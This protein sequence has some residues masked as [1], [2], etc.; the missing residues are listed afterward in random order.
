MCEHRGNRP[1]P[2]QGQPG[3]QPGPYGSNNPYSSNSSNGP[4]GP[5]Q[6]THQPSHPYAAHPSSPYSPFAPPEPHRS[7]WQRLR[8]DDWPPLRQV[9]RVGRQRIPVRIWALVLLPCTSWGVL[10]PMMCYAL[11]RTARRRA[12]QVFPPWR[13]RRVQD[14]DVLRVQRVRAWT[15][16]VISL[17]ILVVYGEPGDFQEARDQYWQRLLITPWL[18]LLSAPVAIAVLFR[19][20][21]PA[22]R[23][24]MR[25]RLRAAGK[26]AL[27]Y[28]G[29]LMAVPLLGVAVVWAL[30]WTGGFVTNPFLLLP[31]YMALWAP[32]L[33]VFFFVAFASAPAVRG[34]FNT[35][36]AH[37]ALPALLTAVLVWELTLVGLLTAGLPPGPPLL[38]AAVLAGGPL[39]VTAVAWWEIHRLRTRHG[40][41]LRA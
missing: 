31:T 30:E 9:L 13:E 41:E 8:E 37:A 29:A 26:S 17:L 3:P 6:P 18:L 4:Y 21:S 27:I 5:P 39:S 1:Y 10:P 25:P 11:A 38:Q 20:A 32:V 36:E 40:V 22:A 12:R 15:A 23:A 2:P 16:A 33:W 14:L 19:M 34:A 7:S 35:A 24:T 28:F